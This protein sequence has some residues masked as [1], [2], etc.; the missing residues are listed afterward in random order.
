MMNILHILNYISMYK[1][2]VLLL[3]NNLSQVIL[4]LFQDKDI[5]SER[6][7]QWFIPQQLEIFL[8]KGLKKFK[9]EILSLYF[10][11]I[12]KTVSLKFWKLVGFWKGYIEF[13]SLTLSFCV[14]VYGGECFLSFFFPFFTFLL[15][16]VYIFHYP[17]IIIWCRSVVKCLLGNNASILGVV[18]EFPSC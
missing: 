7:G 2:E 5:L 12:L 6:R 17:H 9:V 3:G 18:I 15:P 13:S 4:V 8:L 16:S 10:P 1:L 14:C 11:K